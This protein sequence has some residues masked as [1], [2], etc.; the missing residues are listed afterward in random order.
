MW[1][2]LQKPLEAAAFVERYYPRPGV[3]ACQ[4]SSLDKAFYVSRTRNLLVTDLDLPCPATEFRRAHP[5]AL[6]F[7]VVLATHRVKLPNCDCCPHFPRNMK[8]EDFWQALAERVEDHRYTRL[9]IAVPIAESTG[10]PPET[11]GLS[12]REFVALR[13]LAEGCTI[14]ECAQKMQVC[15]TTVENHKYRIM[16][17]LKIHRAHE[18]VLLGA[19]LG[20]IQ[21]STFS[22]TE[23]S[24]AETPVANAPKSA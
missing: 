22:P 7:A 19:R 8:A 12:R 14:T 4:I 24:L 23:R 18:L 3:I 20:W 15:N 16:K 5:D 17:K 1:V 9:R 21:H 13:L 2:C 6:S 10:T 11:S